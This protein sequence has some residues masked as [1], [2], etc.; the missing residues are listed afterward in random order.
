MW[1]FLVKGRRYGP[2][3]TEKV[4][5]LCHKGV[6]TDATLVRNTLFKQWVPAGQVGALRDAIRMLE[7]SVSLEEALADV[8]CR[9]Q[10]R[11]WY[12]FYP[13]RDLET[14]WMVIGMIAGSAAIG[15]MG[16]M[17]ES[18]AARDVVTRLGMAVGTAAGAFMVMLIVGWPLAL[19]GWFASRRLQPVA[20]GGFIVG[21]AAVMCCGISG[22]MN[23]NRHSAETP[24]AELIPTWMMPAQFTDQKPAPSKSAD[25]Q[26]AAAVAQAGPTAT[27]PKAPSAAN[28][29]NTAPATSGRPAANDSKASVMLARTISD[30][31]GAIY[32]RYEA[33]RLANSASKILSPGRL[34]LRSGYDPARRQCADLRN[35]RKQYE[36]ETR[37]F[38]ASIPGRV[39]A[40]GLTPQEQ[41]SFLDG[42]RPTA[43]LASR[44]MLQRIAIDADMLAK[45]ESAIDFMESKFGKFVIKDGGL[46]FMYKYDSDEYSHRVQEL[47]KLITQRRQ[48]ESDYQKQTKQ[49][50]DQF[51]TIANQ[52]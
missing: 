10:Q 43:V 4:Q 14:G 31:M 17:H 13:L 33:I 23:S 28:S 37:A 50:L 25:T 27:Q 38:L 44:Q 21:A 15:T 8:P 39:K 32:D 48:L 7:V 5:D 42:Y 51:A 2:V 16:W 26:P 18:A 29:V 47:A 35:A 19:L 11:S 22:Q 52:P 24:T 30:E 12:A 36:A 34:V 3:S 40:S 45:V 46:A 20:L 9:S 41:K 6:I 1:Y 49:S